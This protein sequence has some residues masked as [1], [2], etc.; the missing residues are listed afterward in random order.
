MSIKHSWEGDANYVPGQTILKTCN[1]QTPPTNDPKNYQTVDRTD[2]L[3]FT[4]D[5][6]WE[7]SD[8]EWASRWD[9]Y[10]LADAPNDKVLYV[11]VLTLLNELTFM[12]L[13]FKEITDCLTH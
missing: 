13:D 6:F 5:V 2:T 12:I 11:L 9:T 1:D 4:Y 10:L 3:V 7:K 8:V